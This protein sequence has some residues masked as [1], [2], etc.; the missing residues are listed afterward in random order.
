[1]LVSKIH[2]LKQLKG[3]LVLLLSSFVHQ[4]KMLVMKRLTEIYIIEASEIICN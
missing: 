3:Q 1:M 2:C 4:E